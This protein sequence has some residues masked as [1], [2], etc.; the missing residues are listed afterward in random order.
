LDQLYR[1]FRTGAYESPKPEVLGREAVGTVVA[2]G[3]GNTFGLQNGD[4][5]CYI[6]PG[7]YAEFTAAP[8]LHAFKLPEGISDKLAASAYIQGLAAITIMSEAHSPVPGQWAL[9]H[10][11]AGGVGLWLC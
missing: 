7:A 5:V 1:Y 3:G 10:A 8:A 9:V 11:A 6:G 4:R 2:I